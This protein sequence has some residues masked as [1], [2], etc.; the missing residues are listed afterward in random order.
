M[1]MWSCDCHMITQVWHVAVYG[2]NLLFIVSVVLAVL[3]GLLLSVHPQTSLMVASCL[4]LS[5][6]V[7]ATKLIESESMHTCLSVCL[8]ALM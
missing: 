4:A 3:L 8:C 7:L 1:V 6:N 5:S 2:G